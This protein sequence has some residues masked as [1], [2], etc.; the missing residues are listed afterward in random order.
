[1]RH[2]AHLRDAELARLFH[3]CPEPFTL[4]DEPELLAIAL[5]ATLYSPATRATL[6]ADIARRAGQGVISTVVCLEDAVAD[7][8]LAAAELNAVAQLRALAEAQV[9]SSM[10]F[11]RVR[12]V[13]QVATVVNSLGP[14]LG[15]LTGFVI[16]K[17]TEDSGVAFLE[18]VAQASS[19]NG[20]RLFAMP[21]V[22]SPEVIHR[23]TRTNAL[24]G[25]QRVLDKYRESVLAVRV[26]A[27]DLSS[28]YGLRRP[29]DLTIYDV[30]LV[31]DAIADTVNILGRADG[32]GFVVTGPVW[33][34]ISISERIFKSQLR[35][36]PFVAHEVRPLRARLVAANLDGLIRE[37][38][39]D[40]ANGLTGKTVIHPMHVAA[41]HALSVVTHEEYT[42]ARAVVGAANAG[43]GVVASEYRNKMNEAKPH[44]SWARRTLQRA[45][46]F[47]V[48]R[49]DVS[50]VDLLDAS[51]S[52]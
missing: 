24:L 1:M 35:E 38:L 36:S 25:I 26:G 29:H 43:G 49:A 47:G 42:D 44:R 4:D 10:V 21:V 33:E 20:Q 6:A 22:E 11:V 50:F 16:P 52:S 12:N 46:V 9:P 41:V 17:F 32:T 48:A 51:L 31:A 18:A 45:Q 3:C 34:H 37:V 19:A 23:E 15:V 30:R 2:F 14:Y 13:E 40:R 7:H 39:L 8:D 28:V 27:T 5:G